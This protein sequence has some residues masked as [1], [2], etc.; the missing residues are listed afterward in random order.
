MKVVVFTGAG[1][2]RESGLPTYRDSDGLWN[3][4]DVM[5]VCSAQAY[6]TNRAGVL[7]FYNQR[8]KDMLQCQPN[9]AHFAVAELEALGF[10]VTVVTQNI[11]DLHERAGSS[12]VIHLHGNIMEKKSD[13]EL[14]SELLSCREDILLEDKAPDGGFYRPNIVFFHEALPEEPFA[15][16]MELTKKTHVM[17]VVGTTLEVGPA[18][19]VV[20]KT[21]AKHVVV[22][23]PVPP[24][25][26]RSLTFDTTRQFKIV[27]EPASTGLDKALEYLSSL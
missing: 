21:R 18:N 26:P 19:N 15:E 14:S 7:D 20:H 23:D 3:G 2:S 24:G 25:L 8:R 1:I 16:A 4:H 11:D 6:A 27:R 12:K 10:N 17:L 22:V 9:R 5:S 13:K